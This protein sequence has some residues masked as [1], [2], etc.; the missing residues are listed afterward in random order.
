MSRTVEVKAHNVRNA[1]AGARR[2]LGVSLKDSQERLRSGGEDGYY[3]I[4]LTNGDVV[5][6]SITPR[7]PTE[8][9]AVH[10]V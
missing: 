6:A 3:R 7:T 1:L 5:E 2:A 8:V 10:Q 9:V 4:H